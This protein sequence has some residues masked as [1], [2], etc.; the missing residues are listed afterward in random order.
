MFLIRWIRE[1]LSIPFLWAGRL[2]VTFKL[3]VDVPLLK[4]A[5]CISKNGQSGFIALTAVNRRQG[6]HAATLQAQ[7][8]MQS[9]PRP[10]VAAFAG[11]LAI[12]ADNTDLA[13]TY[14]QQG[15][16]L[17][18]EK[19]GLLEMLEFFIVSR[20][21]GHDALIRLAQQFSTRDDLS[22]GMSKL[23]L[24]ELLW[25][26]MLQGRWDIAAAKAR[27]LLA[28]ADTP[29]AEA[30]LWALA[31]QRGDPIAAR[32]HLERVKLPTA[33]RA[34]FLCL[35]SAAIGDREEARKFLEE[36]HQARPEMAQRTEAHLRGMKV[37]I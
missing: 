27:Q 26:D 2:A 9:C 12:D 8:W 37:T 25:D 28:V 7:S 5:W 4:A 17:G 32:N 34:Y 23:V 30:A 10:E 19:A 35:G 36:I 21:E 1:L 15:R 31:L 11:L 14:L 24:T 18:D 3:P 22:A 29:E 6:V 16:Q 13:K 33:Q 20:T